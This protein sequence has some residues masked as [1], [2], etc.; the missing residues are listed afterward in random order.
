LHVHGS[1]HNP[2]TTARH[3]ASSGSSAQP[4]RPQTF[5]PYSPVRQA[6]NLIFTSGQVGVDPADRHLDADPIKQA[7][8]ALHNIQAVLESV[9]VR[10]GQVVE[11]T[12]FLTDMDD[13]AGINELY[14]EFFSEPYPARAC[15][16]VKELPRVGGDVPVKV[17]IK[18]IAAGAPI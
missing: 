2:A 8:Q 13:F 5:G 1:A 10:M 11:T 17:E 15:V 9:G 18:A 14:G 16:A 12:I 6:G 3:Q 4:A 7:W